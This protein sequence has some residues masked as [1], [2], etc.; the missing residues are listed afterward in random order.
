MSVL[1]FTYAAQE[2]S[3]GQAENS[4]SSAGIATG[5]GRRKS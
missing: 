4:L 2:L 3:N 1:S 5:E